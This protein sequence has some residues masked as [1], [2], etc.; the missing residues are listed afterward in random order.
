MYVRLAFALAAHLDCDVLLVDEVLAVGD[1]E[2]QQRC[3]ARMRDVATDGR[4]VLL[5]SHQLNTV[6]ALCDRVVYLKQGVVAGEGPTQATLAQYLDETTGQG[7]AQDVSDYVRRP[8]TGEVRMVRL[9]QEPSADP[10]RLRWTVRGLSGTE[11]VYV[12]FHVVNE[13]GVTLLQCD[14]RLVTADVRVSEGTE[15]EGSFVLHA[16]ALKPGRYQVD[17]FVC[18]R[19]DLVDVV[20]D[21]LRFDVSPILPY[22][23]AAPPDATQSGL[24]LPAFG[25]AAGDARPC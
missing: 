22:P 1:Q 16:P 13:L 4:T 9:E 19:A 23:R 2:F 12:S 17:A 20:E 24:V 21:A 25:Y 7:H 3:I 11:T 14:S 6:A 5:V 18:R 10:L 8:G 15:V